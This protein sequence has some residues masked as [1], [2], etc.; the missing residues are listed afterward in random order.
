ML[1]DD[2]LSVLE[3]AY[4]SI[5]VI[6]GRLTETIEVQPENKFLPI[7]FI[8]GRST[9]IVKE[10][11]QKALSPIHSTKGKSIELR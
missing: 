10:Q 2:K 7:D 1:N 6:T 4:P 3:K 5:C 11:F 8:D 9:L